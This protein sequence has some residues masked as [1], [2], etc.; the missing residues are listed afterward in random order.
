MGAHAE[1]LAQSNNRNNWGGKS[2]RF[3]G[4]RYP[5]D[6]IIEGDTGLTQQHERQ[7]DKEA[8]AVFNAKVQ[9]WGTKVDAAL[10]IS[11]GN[12]IVT[13]KKLSKSMK[14]NYRHYGKHPT[15]GEEITSI[16]FSFKEEGVY[17][18]LGVGRG[19]NMEGSSRVLTK[20]SDD[21]WNREPKPWFNPIIEQHIP[22][23]IE[24]VKE[25]CGALVV[26][27]TRIFINT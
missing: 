6:V 10:R 13:D 9:A 11:I 4:E 15:E 22:E 14:Q 8:V 27:A 1:R 23:L 16:G 5:L 3:A 19:Y 7:L 17:V 18:H 26:N 2:N 21:K 25:Y 20:K 24:I 12:N